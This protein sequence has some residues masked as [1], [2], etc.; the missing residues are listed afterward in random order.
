MT[1]EQTDF[2]FSS[3][4]WFLVILFSIMFPVLALVIR[5]SKRGLK[6]SDFSKTSRYAMVSYYAIVAILLGW[7]FL[8][9]DEWTINHFALL[10]I[11]SLVGVVG[12]LI[13]YLRRPRPTRPSR[14][15][16]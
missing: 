6:Q 10:L 16:H 5:T 13:L 4:T 8:F 7:A 14:G 15:P 9:P 2:V 1:Q 11:L 3:Q 12:G